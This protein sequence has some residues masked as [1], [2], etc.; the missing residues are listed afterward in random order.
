MSDI[1]KG[2]DQS[3]SR[4]CKNNYKCFVALLY[5]PFDWKLQMVK[6]KGDSDDLNTILPLNTSISS[7]PKAW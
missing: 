7:D 1:V 2:Q 6:V 4:A 3:A 5:Y